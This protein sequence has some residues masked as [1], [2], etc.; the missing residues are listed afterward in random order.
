MGGVA[1]RSLAVVRDGAVAYDLVE[2]G[3]RGAYDETV[4]GMTLRV[5]H[6]A[7]FQTT[8]AGA[9]VLVATVAAHVG[10]DGVAVLDACCGGGLLG[11]ALAKRGLRAR[12]V[13][14][15]AD[16]CADARANAA[17]NGLAFPV[18]RAKVEH[19]L[20]DV[21]GADEGP[22][23]VVLDPPRAGLAPGVARA[24]RRSA[25]CARVV[26]VSCNPCGT[27]YRA[28]F[29]VKGGGLQNTIR[30]LTKRGG[31]DAPFKLTRATPVDLFPHTPHCE[32]VL[33]FDRDEA[34]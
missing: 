20:A 34:T 11:L 3:S 9:G 21:L 10:D 31:R 25:K 27:A 26:L 22:V 8:S 7:F 28:D 13:E 19:A 2:G 23:C 4:D 1:L 12:G 29:V 33:R 14:V 32:L 18:T 6:G 17:R 15:V 5:S 24:V 30:L 16:A